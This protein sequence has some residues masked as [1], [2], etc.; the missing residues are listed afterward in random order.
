MHN[1]QHI[2]HNR[3]YTTQDKERDVIDGELDKGVYMY[4]NQVILNFD[5]LERIRRNYL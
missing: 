3:E 1:I 4:E 5:V 2:T